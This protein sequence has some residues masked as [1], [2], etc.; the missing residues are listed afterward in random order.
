[1][2]K[3]IDDNRY[4]EFN[5]DE[6]WDNFTQFTFNKLLDFL[7]FPEKDRPLIIPVKVDRNFEAYS[8]DHLEPSE[9]INE[10]IEVLR[11]YDY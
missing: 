5:I 3:Q 1:M 8:N 11:S 2:N 7:E 10:K 6:D 9:Y 4:F